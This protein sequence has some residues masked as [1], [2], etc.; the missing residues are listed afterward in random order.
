MADKILEFKKVSYKNKNFALNDISFCLD[1]GYVLGVSGKNG[2]GKST[3]LK[4]IMNPGCDYEGRILIDG[5]DI[6]ANRTECL[7]KICFVSSE[8]QYFEEFS[9]ETNAK[10]FGASYANFDMDVFKSYIKEFEVPLVPSYKSLSWGQ[11]IRFMLAFGL[12]HNSELFLFDEATAGMDVVFRKDFF[13]LVRELI[14]K[15]NISVLMVTH[16]DEE[17]KFQADYTMIMDNGSM[18]EFKENII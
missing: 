7:E 16:L 5:K 4:L 13:R 8:Q 6:K 14:D 9:A 2:A 17:M 10:V 1:N 18:I 15:N 3:L 11:K 12:A